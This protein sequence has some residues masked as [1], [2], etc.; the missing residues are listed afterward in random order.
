MK[1]ILLGLLLIASVATVSAQTP[2]TTNTKTTKKST[3]AVHKRTTANGNSDGANLGEST[4][5]KH[6]GW[7]KGKH[8]G[9]KAR[10]KQTTTTTTTASDRQ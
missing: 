2:E 10:V 5:K 9:R 8:K 7:T 3:H 4:R 1:K 6:Y